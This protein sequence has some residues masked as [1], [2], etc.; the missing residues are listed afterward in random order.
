MAAQISPEERRLI[1]EAIARR[2]IIP[3]G[4]TAPPAAPQ[5][6]R[7]PRG[8]RPVPEVA[9][10][11]AKVAAMVG[12]GL[13][14][15]C[16]MERLGVNA[17]IIRNDMTFLGLKSHKAQPDPNIKDKAA[18]KR[19]ARVATGLE[20]LARIRA[21]KITD[22]RRF[23]DTPVPLGIPNRTVVKTTTGTI[24]PNMVRDVIPGQPVL[25]DGASNSKIGGDVRVGWLKGAKI[26]T[27]TLEERATCPSYCPL[28]QTCYGNSMNWSIRWRPG[29]VLEAQIEADVKRL[30][31]LH[32]RILVR[33]HILGDFPDKTYVHLWRRLLREY[34]GLNVFGFTAHRDDTDMGQAI[35]GIRSDF[36]RRFNIRHSGR[37]G[38]WGSIT[39][40][41]VEIDRPMI[42]DVAMC[43]EQRDAMS[44]GKKGMHCGD[45][46]L[47]WTGKPT[48]IGFFIH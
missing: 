45:C 32:G 46:G 20:K 21:A 37:S 31:D 39:T 26:F 3:A 27:L 33:L 48:P 16:M 13:S 23:K 15:A 35:A 14:V 36:P 24:F 7:K 11:R 47:C 10:R 34:P 12:E 38:P 29:P 2:Q 30:T 4:V 42:L 25:V 8:K 40:D 9:Q 19:K 41:M 43:L 28:W 22:R 6:S 44:G 17:F 5:G 18:A 1:D